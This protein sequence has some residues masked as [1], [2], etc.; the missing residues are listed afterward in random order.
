MLG[1]RL[2]KSC[3][4]LK[5]IIINNGSSKISPSYMANIRLSSSVSQLI[6]L[7]PQEEQGDKIR[8]L[9]RSLPL[10]RFHDSQSNVSFHNTHNQQRLWGKSPNFYFKSSVLKPVLFYICSA[11][12]TGHQHVLEINLQLKLAFQANPELSPQTLEKEGEQREL[13]LM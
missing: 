5:K 8:C 7:V 3:K 10:R 4:G 9:L 12:T 1:S 2:P 6:V 11:M 13:L